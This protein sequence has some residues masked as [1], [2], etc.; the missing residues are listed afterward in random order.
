MPCARAKIVPTD[1]KKLFAYPVF[2]YVVS[3]ILYSNI[4]LESLIHASDELT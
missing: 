3:F 4:K 2:I 1:K